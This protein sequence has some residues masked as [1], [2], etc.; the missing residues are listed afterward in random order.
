MLTIVSHTRIGSAV[1]LAWP[2]RCPPV[3]A[4]VWKQLSSG[5]LLCARRD[6]LYSAVQTLCW[7]PRRIE[8]NA[9]FALALKEPCTDVVTDEPSASRHSQA[10]RRVFAG[11][12]FL[13]GGVV[14][15]AWIAFGHPPLRE[16]WFQADVVSDPARQRA[17]APRKLLSQ[18]KVPQPR[19]T[20]LPVAIE[21]D[22]MPAPVT[23][24][25]KVVRARPQPVGN[26]TSD[27]S[28]K[29]RQHDRQAAPHTWL[30]SD[31]MGEQ[32]RL[33]AAHR[34]HARDRAA[35]RHQWARPSMSG[36]NQ[37]ASFGHWPD[38]RPVT[39]VT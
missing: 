38:E 7:E 20:A 35:D 32:T 3:S 8:Q 21:T 29:H 39:A 5:I 27:V 24:K 33:E 34:P 6:A 11:P 15:C 36:A 23:M 14:V 31:S 17:V 12:A 4:Y 25:T 18:C 2:S 30:P 28:R 37:D 16:S 13:I 1:P 26:G 9:V 10:R 19:S 22:R